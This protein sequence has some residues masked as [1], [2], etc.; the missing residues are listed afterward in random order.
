MLPHGGEAGRTSIHMESTQQTTANASLSA[1]ETEGY[2]NFKA[3]LADLDESTC[4]TATGPDRD[5]EIEAAFLRL[6]EAER[7]WREAILAESAVAQ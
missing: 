7:E 1:R 5:R 6:A 3:A 4:K 2:N